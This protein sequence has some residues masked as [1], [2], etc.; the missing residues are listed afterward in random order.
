MKKLISLL[1]VLTM[2]LILA[3]CG[4]T[5]KNEEV[6]PAATEAAAPATEAAVPETEAPASHYPVTVTDHAG[7]VAAPSVQVAQD[8][9]YLTS[10]RPAI[11]PSTAA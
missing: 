3:A 5:G 10:L 2:L 9:G 1:L 7:R 6:T 4:Q 11:A 8:S